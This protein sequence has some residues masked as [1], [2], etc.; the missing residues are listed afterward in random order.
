M[1]CTEKELIFLVNFRNDLTI[2]LIL[3]L[4][5]FDKSTCSRRFE[6]LISLRVFESGSYLDLIFE[7][8]KQVFRLSF[9]S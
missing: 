5:L 9:L 7:F 6:G 2:F 4:R 8:R 1:F 3:I